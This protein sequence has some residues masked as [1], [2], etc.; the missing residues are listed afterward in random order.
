[1]LWPYVALGLVPAGPGI[2]A[3]GSKDRAE[4]SGRDQDGRA[5][6]LADSVV[7]GSGRVDAERPVTIS[8]V[9]VSA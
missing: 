7:G 3:A 5:P 6:G 8:D 4:A 2:E 1:M 9:V